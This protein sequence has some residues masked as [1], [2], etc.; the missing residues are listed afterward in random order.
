MK[1]WYSVLFLLMTELIYALY[2]V[3]GR[4]KRNATPMNDLPLFIPY[5]VR[6]NTLLPKKFFQPLEIS[7]CGFHLLTH[8]E[9]KYSLHLSFTFTIKQV[10]SL[11]DEVLLKVNSGYPLFKAI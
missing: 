9:S 7:S 3:F 1:L 11:P 2:T 8:R 5:S 10:H 4:A 6:W